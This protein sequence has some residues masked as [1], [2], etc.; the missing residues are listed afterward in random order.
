MNNFRVIF[1]TSALIL[2]SINT[3]YARKG[4]T[5]RGG[6]LHDSPRTNVFEDIDP[7]MGY[8]GSLGY[9]IYWRFGAD[10]GVM[11]STHEFRAGLRGNA[12]LIDNAEKTSFFIRGRFSPLKMEK[13]EIQI[14]AGPTYYGI[15]GDM[16]TSYGLPYEEGY[17]GWGYTAGVDF[18]HFATENLAI[19]V[20]LAANIVKFSKQ[21]LNSST[22]KPPT[23]LPR[24]D[25]F[26]W[27]LTLYYRIGKFKFN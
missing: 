25:S 5:I 17:S 27:G 24:G 22:V 13:Y 20:Y 1:I 12:V 18:M 8:I 11:H 15:T 23:R 7:G 19:T 14:G 9:D 26:S 6:L 21:T 3:G 10:L 16:I 2:V 4:L